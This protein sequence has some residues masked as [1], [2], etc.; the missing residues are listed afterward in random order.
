MKKKS[1]NATVSEENASI[2]NKCD[3]LQATAKGTTVY[4]TK[5]QDSSSHNNLTNPI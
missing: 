5:L 2:Q 1:I 3:W 4:Q